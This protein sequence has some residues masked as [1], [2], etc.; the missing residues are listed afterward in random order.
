MAN[1]VEIVLWIDSRWK[2][3][4]EKQLKGETL[5]EHLE[6]VLDQLCNQL[7][8]REYD[9]ISYEIQSEALAAREA[10]EAQRKYAAF[11]IT[12]HGREC[13]FKDSTGQEFL[14]VAAAVRNYLREYFSEKFPQFVSSFPRGM[15]ISPEKYQSLMRLRMEN[16]GKV[17]GVFDIDFDKQEF[18]AVDIM[19]GWKSWSIQDISTAAYHAFRKDYAGTEERYKKL[20]DYLEGKE[21]TTAGHLSA[22]NFVFGDEIIEQDGK[23]N[24]YVQT[25]FDVDK[26]FGTNVCTAE[27]DDWLNICANYDMESG[28]VCDTLELTLCKGDGTE[29]TFSYRLNAAERE[30]LLH[31]MD[32][33]CRQ[34]TDMS[35]HEYAKQLQTEQGQ[36]SEMRM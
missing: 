8:E 24:F 22:R 33:F 13:Y 5:R 23:L 12:E 35:L 21:F 14:L 3:A 10:E 2:T 30:V 28:T 4:I 26:V 1:S 16:T 7:P 18:S 27:N 15:C 11:H 36:A 17:T 29:E 31:K 25:E 34:E 20:L 32:E 6:E 9:R 19:D